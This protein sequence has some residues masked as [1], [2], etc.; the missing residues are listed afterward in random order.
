MRLILASLVA[1][2]ALFAAGGHR[3]AQDSKPALP[4]PLK[5]PGY[6]AFA[7]HCAPCHGERGDGKGVAARFLEPPPRDFKREPFRLVSTENNAPS[8]KDLFETIATGVG[9]TA[10]VPFAGLGDDAL[11][12]IVEVVQAFR[13]Q[14]VRMRLE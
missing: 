7:R 13:L 14:G 12:P 4:D 5:L 2:A 8:P 11:W 9:G 3:A 1:I 10:M 6:K